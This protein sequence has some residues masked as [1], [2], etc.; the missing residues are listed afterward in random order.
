ME[1]EASKT[2]QHSRLSLGGQWKVLNG[3]VDGSRIAGMVWILLYN[4][5]R[6]MPSLA[7]AGLMSLN[8]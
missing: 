8:V 4:L 5:S 3:W 2:G 1:Q 6:S 7:Y